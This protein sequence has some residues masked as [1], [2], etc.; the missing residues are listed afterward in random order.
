MSVF[1]RVM[2]VALSNAWDLPRVSFLPLNF[3]TLVG[4]SD[5]NL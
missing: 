2:N 3:I 1:L 5:S 4:R